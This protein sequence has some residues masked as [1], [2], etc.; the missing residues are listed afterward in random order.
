MSIRGGSKLVG[1]RATTRFFCSPGGGGRKERI[2]T[3]ALRRKTIWKSFSNTGGQEDWRDQLISREGELLGSAKDGVRPASGKFRAYGKE[4]KGITQKLK[5]QKIT[6]HRVVPIT[7]K[8]R[9]LQKYWG[10]KMAGVIFCFASE[11]GKSRTRL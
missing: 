3:L 6:L 5:V 7:V 8:K 2:K 10:K 11:I 9:N 1:G 4:K